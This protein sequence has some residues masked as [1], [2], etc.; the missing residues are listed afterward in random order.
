MSTLAIW[1]IVLFSVT[2][3]IGILVTYLIIKSIKDDNR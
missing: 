2:P 1:F 3:F